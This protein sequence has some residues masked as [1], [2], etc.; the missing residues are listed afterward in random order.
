MRDQ[1][2]SALIKLALCPGDR[3][4]PEICS[5]CHYRGAPDCHKQLRRESLQISQKVLNLPEDTTLE[6]RITSLLHDMG[7]PSHIKG[8]RYVRFAILSTVQNPELI[9]DMLCGLYP[10]VAKEFN[11]TYSR[12]ERAIR[13]AL[14]LAWERGDLSVLQKWFGWSVNSSRGRPTSSEFI[15]LIA[16]RLRL[17]MKKGGNTYEY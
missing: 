13:H 5:R 8:F 17:E 9:E 7:I 15:A 1:T 12:A 14:E 2:L 10:L 11:T 16:D 4:D 3:S 6:M